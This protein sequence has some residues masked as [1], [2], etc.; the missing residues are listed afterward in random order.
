MPTLLSGESNSLTL[1]FGGKEV[2]V[3]FPEY[4]ENRRVTTPS[5]MLCIPGV[6][7]STSKAF[8]QY[9]TC[10]KSMFSMVNQVHS[11]SVAGLKGSGRNQ[12][13]DL[14]VFPARDPHNA[15]LAKMLGEGDPVDEISLLNLMWVKGKTPMIT[16]EFKFGKAKIITYKE[17]RYFS[18]CVF[19]CTELLIKVNKFAQA[20]GALEGTNEVKYNYAQ[21]QPNN[22]LKATPQPASA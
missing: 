2:R 1:M 21:L 8:P 3:R 5:Q 9:V 12:L 18:A 11:S 7:E 17:A 15:S 14:V 16:S 13:T 4:D 20:D 22:D 6:T 19:R 10:Y